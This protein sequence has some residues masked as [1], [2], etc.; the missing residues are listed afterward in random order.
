MISCQWRGVKRIWLLSWK[1]ALWGARPSRLLPEVPAHEAEARRAAASVCTPG[2]EPAGRVVCTASDICLWGPG[3]ATSGRVPSG[4]AGSSPY[5]VVRDSSAPSLK[6]RSQGG[7]RCSAAGRCPRVQWL[8]RG[9]SDWP[10]AQPFHSAWSKLGRAHVGHIG[11]MRTSKLVMDYH[12][13]WEGEANS[14]IHN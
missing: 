1:A 2:K 8:V 7:Q 4:G 5:S 6:S 10:H 3:A 13:T 11:V 12:D 14:Q 9:P